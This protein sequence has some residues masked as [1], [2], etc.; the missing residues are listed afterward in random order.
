[1]SETKPSFFWYVLSF[2]SNKITL[3]YW[4]WNILCCHSFS[5]LS[6]LKPKMWVYQGLFDF[7]VSVQRLSLVTKQQFSL[8]LSGSNSC[9]KKQSFLYAVLRMTLIYVFVLFQKPSLWLLILRFL[10]AVVPVLFEIKVKLLLWLN[11]TKLWHSKRKVQRTIESMFYCVDTFK[12][13]V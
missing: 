7:D 9:T 6:E 11:S 2:P 1:M 10:L 4:S 5:I 8:L 12:P 13:L 3:N